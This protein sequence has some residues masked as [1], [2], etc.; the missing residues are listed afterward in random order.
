MPFG[1]AIASENARPFLHRPIREV[2]CNAEGVER[3]ERATEG[4]AYGTGL[5]EKAW[6]KEQADRMVLEVPMV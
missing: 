1:H 3:R 4:W 6:G 5:V 2:R